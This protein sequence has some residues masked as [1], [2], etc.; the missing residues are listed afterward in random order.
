[1][2]RFRRE[3]R[4]HDLLERNRELQRERHERLRER[5][6]HLIDTT[7][8]DTIERVVGISRKAKTF[9]EKYRERQQFKLK[10]EDIFFKTETLKT[11]MVDN[12]ASQNIISREKIIS[13][14]KHG[15]DRVRQPDME[16]LYSLEKCIARYHVGPCNS[17]KYYVKLT[18][19]IREELLNLA[20]KMAI[21]IRSW[22]SNE[23]LRDR[24]LNA[25]AFVIHALLR[26]RTK[27]RTEDYNM[28]YLGNPESTLQESDTVEIMRSDITNTARSYSLGFL[29]R[30]PTFIARATA[31]K[32]GLAE[33]SSDSHHC[34]IY[35][36]RTEISKRKHYRGLDFQ[37]YYDF[38]I[39]EDKERFR[40]IK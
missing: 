18:H 11:Y 24:L 13:A 31:Y 8:R 2:A 28:E 21:Y 39:F 22:I 38:I 4:I 15:L 20:L 17:Y 32:L 40:G 29:M 37:R 6:K 35:V 26:S 7:I 36:H 9:N 23:K 30:H 12:I 1:M 3:H 16:N 27:S 33:Y 19:M 34:S 25:I 14:V 5:T 10:I